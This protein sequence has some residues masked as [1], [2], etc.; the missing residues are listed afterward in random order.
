MIQE[1]D[2]DVY[3]LREWALV[4][5]FEI[6]P[7]PSPR[8][9]ERGLPRVERVANAIF[10]YVATGY[11]REEDMPVKAPVKLQVVVGGKSDPAVLSLKKFLSTNAPDAT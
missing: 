4:T 7:P 10:N 2:Y 9:L 5:A 3:E 1:P 11:M 6:V 8:N